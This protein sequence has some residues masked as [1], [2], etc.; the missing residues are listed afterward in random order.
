MTEKSVQLWAKKKNFIKYISLQFK[1]M[2]CDKN[3][4]Y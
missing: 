3:V 2:W 1:E 4:P